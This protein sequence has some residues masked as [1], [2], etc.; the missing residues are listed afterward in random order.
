MKSHAF[1]DVIIMNFLLGYNTHFISLTPRQ[2]TISAIFC[3]FNCR[4]SPFLTSTIQ[5]LYDSN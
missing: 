2:N 1:F 5:I 3:A 4:F